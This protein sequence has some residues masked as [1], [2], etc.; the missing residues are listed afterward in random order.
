MTTTTPDASDV[1]PTYSRPGCSSR[2]MCAS[3]GRAWT[4][5]VDDI[6][7]DAKGQREEIVYGNGT[8]RRTPYDPVTFR[9]SRLK[10]V[11]HNE[12]STVSVLQ[13]LSYTASPVGNIVAI[14]DG[15]AN[16]VL[17]QRCGV[18]QYPQYV[19]DAIYRLVQASGR[20]H[21]GGVG[22]VQRDQNDLPLMNLPHENDSAALRNYTELYGYDE[23]GNILSMV[24]QAGMAGSWT[25]RYEVAETSNRLL[26]TS[27]P[28]DGESAPYS[29]TY[30][31]DAH[32]NMTAMPHL[33]SVGWDY[34]DQ[35]LS[36][37]LGGGGV[38]YYTYDAGGQRV[39]K[40]W[41]HSGLVEE[42]IYLGGYEVYRKRDVSGL[43]LERQTLH[44][45][46]GEKR[47][48]LVETTTVD[49]A[50]GGSFEVSTVI[51]YQMGN[52]L[53]SA[54]LEVDGEGAVISYE[55][56]HPYGT[57]AY[58]SGTG[59][60]EVSLRRFRYTGK[61]KDEGTGLYYHG[62][63]YYVPWIGR[64]TSA[65]PC[66][67]VDGPNLHEYVQGNPVRLSDPSG[68][69]SAPLTHYSGPLHEVG[70]HPGGGMY[71]IYG[72]N[73]MIKELEIAGTKAQAPLGPPSWLANE[74]NARSAAP[75]WLIDAM[76]ESEGEG[77]LDG[78]L[79]VEGGQRD[80]G[81]ALNFVQGVG[82][83]LVQFGTGLMDF[84]VGRGPIES[85]KELA[86]QLADRASSP[87]EAAVLATQAV[88]PFFHLA[89]GV[90]RLLEARDAREAGQAVGNLAGAAIVARV[91]AGRARARPIATEELVGP[92]IAE[93]ENTT[94]GP[95]TVG[96]AERPPAESVPFTREMH[97]TSEVIARGSS[98]RK[99]DELVAKFGGTRRGWVKK[100]TWDSSSGAEIHYYEHHGIGRV[101]VKWAGESDPF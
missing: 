7:Y 82:E 49:E 85:T 36:S 21:A 54:V 62:A 90:G 65:D 81:T 87:G 71:A 45:M 79:A 32:G 6:D 72:G 88:N 52:H 64:W 77:A 23:V 35:M 39:R 59:A 47:V 15:A 84:L 69:Q 27:L 26:S 2:W 83:G 100:K 34:R 101:G 43:L 94:F 57:S 11:R 96:A 55:E 76:A 9:L 46:D 99:I 30:S 40:V 91:M 41:E 38:V 80:Y 24:H 4:D 74:V 10:T 37:D 66:G 1:R 92:R 95:R 20:E 14:A 18:R 60:A 51:R 58:R 12:D 33:P 42:R 67:I 73:V 89:V 5:F 50:A 8:G 16:G 98:I 63:R 48:S 97:S 86:A 28:G 13:N 53:G 17:Q 22:D 56:Y 75:I 93:I 61:E 29:A 78:I 44:V 25:R 19:Y 70:E 68:L 3:A 31:Y